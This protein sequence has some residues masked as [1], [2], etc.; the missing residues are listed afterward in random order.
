MAIPVLWLCGPAGV[1]KT[2]VGWEIY[3]RLARAGVEAAYVDSDQLGMCYPEPAEDPGRHRLQARNLEAILPNLEASG[4][5][6]VIVSGVVD[7]ARGVQLPSVN[8]TVCRLRVDR[9]ELARRFAGRGT[10]MDRAD[11]TLLEADKLDASTFADVCV[12]TTG[13]SVAEV[14]GQILE[15]TQ[16]PVLGSA[17]ATAEPS[18]RAADGSILWLC[19]ATGVGKSAI[20][21]PVYL[22][23]LAAGLTAAYIDRDQLGFRGPTPAGHNLWAANLAAV[24]RTYRAA[25]AQGLVVVG[26]VEDEAAIQAYADALPAATITVCRL[27]AGRDE[28]TKR[29]LT[30]GAGGSWPQPG[31]PIVGQPTARLLQIADEAVAEAEALER[32]GLGLRIDTDGRTIEESAEEIIARTG[33][34]QSSSPSRSPSVSR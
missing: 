17:P 11:D 33:W 9:D 22:R 3:S 14:A 30:R 7:A 31:D 8:L 1:G 26:A 18:D 2:T 15:R 12:D 6:C 32:A 20:G 28:L 16:W 21:F 10:M 27:H 25:G 4:A 19:G 13:R 24:W 29:I 23:A 5:Q 34:P